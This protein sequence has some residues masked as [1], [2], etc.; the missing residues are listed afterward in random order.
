MPG[1]SRPRLIQLVQIRQFQPVT[2]PNRLGFLALSGCNPALAAL[3]PQPASVRE[4]G[5]HARHTLLEISEHDAARGQELPSCLPCSPR[6]DESVQDSRQLV[7]QPLGEGFVLAAF[8]GMGK[9]HGHNARHESPRP[10]AHCRQRVAREDRKSLIDE[11]ESPSIF[12]VGCQRVSTSQS[13]QVRDARHVLVGHVGVDVDA[14]SVQ[15]SDG[16]LV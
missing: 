7:C 13:L 16:E 9:A 10:L 5:V 2:R 6:F 3:L 14:F 12:H 8:L 15:I 4:E 1:S 11:R